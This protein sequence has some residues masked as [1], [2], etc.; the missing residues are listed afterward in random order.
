LY[1]HGEKAKAFW[2]LG[3][4]AHLLEDATVPAHVH[5][6]AHVVDWMDA[7]ETYMGKAHQRFPVD[8]TGQIEH[9]DNLLDLF[10]S[11]ALVS[12]QFDCGNGG[13][14]SGGVDGTVDR[15]HRRKGGFTKAK[16]DDEGKTLMPL[17]F[18]RV[19][20]L[21]QLFFEEAARGGANP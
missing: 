19:A 2:Y 16:L 12:A 4:I 1:N 6:F 7:Y 8:S 21:Y 18:N 20:A 15:G 5:L 14:L 10:R 17:A 11:T 3:H 9:F 13:G